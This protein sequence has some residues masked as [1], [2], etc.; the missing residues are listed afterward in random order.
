MNPILA[1]DIDG[2]L[3]SGKYLKEYNLEDDESCVLDP[4]RLKYIKTVL[5]SNKNIN[6]IMNSSW[7]ST[8]NLEDYKSLFSK[9]LSDF[10]VERII[11][12]TESS[13][14]K[15]TALVLWLKNNQPSNFLVIDDDCLF[16]LSHPY[17]DHQLKTNYY[18]GLTKNHIDVI[19]EVLENPFSIMN[20]TSE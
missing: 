17:F 16:D 15:T 20:K 13:C 2:V 18:L 7:N 10:P 19:I 5:E 12:V 8:F 11:D 14:D 9:Y 1:L 4:E 6:L 3:N